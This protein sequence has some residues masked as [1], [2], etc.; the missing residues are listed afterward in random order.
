[1]PKKWDCI[2]I[3]QREADARRDKIGS[4]QRIYKSWIDVSGET[5]GKGISTEKEKSIKVLCRIFEGAETTPFQHPL[6]APWR[7]VGPS[8][9][10]FLWAHL[11]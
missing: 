7:Q 5:G 3:Q 8:Q 1:M 9:K 6:L 2:L 4:R 10:L 11:P